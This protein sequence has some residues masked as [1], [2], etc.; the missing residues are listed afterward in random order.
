MNYLNLTYEG[1]SFF[2]LTLWQN[3]W[4]TNRSNYLYKITLPVMIGARIETKI[5][6]LQNPCSHSAAQV[7]FCYIVLSS[8]SIL[9]CPHFV[10]QLFTKELGKQGTNLMHIKIRTKRKIFIYFS[11]VSSFNYYPSKISW[12]ALGCCNKIGEF[13]D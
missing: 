4:Y 7:P 11:P 5:I 6:W 8:C 13:W 1:I 9:D 10:I 2:I 3:M 12:A